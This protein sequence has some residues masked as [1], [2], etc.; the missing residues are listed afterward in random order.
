MKSPETYSCRFFINQNGPVE[1]EQEALCLR[2]S[3]IFLHFLEA[4]DYGSKLRGFWFYSY[5]ASDVN[6]GLHSDLVHNGYARLSASISKPFFDR[7]SKDQKVEFLLNAAL[8]MLR[9]LSLYLAVPKGFEAGLLAADFEKFLT[10]RAQLLKESELGDVVIKH[11]E[12]TRFI[13]IQR[14]TTDV[15]KANIHFDL[16]AIQDF[17]NN[18]LAGRTF[19]GAVRAIHFWIEIYDF[20]SVFTP[21]MKPKAEF[22]RYGSKYKVYFFAK[23]FDYSVLKNMDSFAQ[24]HFLKRSILEGINDHDSLKS[25]VRNFDKG[26]LYEAMEMLLTDY[27]SL[28]YLKS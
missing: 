24:Y 20:N 26:A 12:T 27:E 8:V 14:E 13:F 3:R 1:K 28:N 25:K 22:Q 2:A 5:I 16:N 6:F 17:L 15:D 18:G 19:G 7:A 10:M 21:F 11:F 9:Y 23:H 4:K